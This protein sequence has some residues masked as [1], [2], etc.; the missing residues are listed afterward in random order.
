[1][2]FVSCSRSVTTV[3]TALILVS[4]IATASCAEQISTPQPVPQTDVVIDP[5][6]AA[7][8]WY[9][10]NHSGSIAVYRQLVEKYPENQEYILSLVVLLRERGHMAEALRYSATLNGA[11]AAEHEATLALAGIPAGEP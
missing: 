9:E 7:A 4:V 8:R 3:C 2:R 5:D 6:V 1:M 11:L 10:G